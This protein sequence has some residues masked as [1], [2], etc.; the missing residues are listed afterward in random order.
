MPRQKKP[1][2]NLQ[3]KE[4]DKLA[5]FG[6]Q[7]IP[8]REVAARLQVQPTSVATYVREGKLTRHMINARLAC[9]AVADVERLRQELLARNAGEPPHRGRPRKRV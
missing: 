9:Y 7:F 6:D 4:S 3:V 8:T 2:L 1:V 5:A